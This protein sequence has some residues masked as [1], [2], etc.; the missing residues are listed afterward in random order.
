M[1]PIAASIGHGPQARIWSAQVTRS[2]I[3]SVTRPFTPKEPS[4]VVAMYSTLDGSR[5]DGQRYATLRPPITSVTLRFAASCSAMTRIGA[6]PVP[7]AMSRRL[8]VSRR[9]TNAVPSGPSRSSPSPTWRSAIHSPP[10]PSGFTMSSISPPRRSMRVNEYGRR[11]S[12][13]QP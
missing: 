10:V 9:T 11:R 13:S 3:T 6:M 2:G 5:S 12:G 7:P 8:R 4:S 1:R